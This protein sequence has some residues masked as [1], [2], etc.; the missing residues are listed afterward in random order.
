MKGLLL[1][2]IGNYQRFISPYKG[3][4]CAHRVYKGGQGCSAYG[5]RAIAR[6]GARKG[7]ALLHRR[8][9]ACGTQFRLHNPRMHLQAGSCDL[10]SADCHGCDS[11][12]GDVLDAAECC[13]GVGNCWPGRSRDMATGPGV[14]EKKKEYA[15]RRR[16]RDRN[17]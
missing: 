17:G 5:Y 6:H 3:Y 1:W 16:E 10:P 14:E 4:S 11:T 12:C 15:R 7:L 2:A 13:S 8:L 9:R